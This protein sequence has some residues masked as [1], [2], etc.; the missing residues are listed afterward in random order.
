[1]ETATPRSPV[2]AQRA[3]IEKVVRFFISHTPT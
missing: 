3:T 1:V 2:C